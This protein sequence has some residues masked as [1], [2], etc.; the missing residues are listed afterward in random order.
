[1]FKGF[2]HAGAKIIP[3]LLRRLIAN[4]A[5]LMGIKLPRYIQWILLT[6]LCLLTVMSL[7]RLCFHLY[8]GLGP[9]AGGGKLADAFL[10]GLRYDL[11]IVAIASLVLF[12]FGLIKPLHP[13]NTKRG[14]RVSFFL[15]G[16][17]CF[18]FCLLYIADFAH[19]AYLRQRLNASVL[20]YLEDAAISIKMAWQSYP[21]IWIIVALAGGS[22]LLAW[23]VKRCYNY[24]LGKQAVLTGRSR[25]VWGIVFFLLLALAIFGRVG[26]YPL[27][28]SDAYGLGNDYAANLSLNPFQSFFSS[29][30][31][32]HSGYDAKALKN[33]YPWMAN[34]LEVTA[35]HTDSLNFLRQVSAFDSAFQQP[36]VILVLCES[37]SSFKSSSFNNP[38]NSTPYFD[39][40]AKQGI[41]FTNCYTPC[42]GTARGVWATI[43]GV[44]DVEQS[45]TAS[46]NPAM[47]DQHTII[48]SFEGYEK[49]Y[50][51]GG[52]SSW[53]N[54]RGLLTNN[55]KGLK[56]FEEEHFKAPKVDV[57]GISDKNLFLEAHAELEKTDKPFFAII[58]T[59]GNHR[60]YTIPEEDL[61]EFNKLDVPVDSLNNYGF[62]NVE[63]Y[64][65]FRYM[66]YS[67][68]KFMQAASTAAYFRNTV[69]VFIGDHGI[70]GDVGKILPKKAYTE[71]GLTAMHVPLLFY[72]PGMQPQKINSIASQVDVLPTLAGL[73][74]ISYQNKGLGRD[75]LKPHT[76]SGTAFYFDVEGRRYGIIRDSLFYSRSL[77]SPAQ[78]QLWSL[79]HD[80]PVPGAEKRKEYENISRAFYE[81][82]RYM[83]LN[84]KKNP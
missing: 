58:Q 22:V 67:I 52:S 55:I 79:Y 33:A 32:R 16:L 74:N 4:F 25:I 45:K 40:L 51:L 63:E 71:Q 65:A 5:R 20:N 6:G 72:K 38:L 70:R 68:R 76:V 54:I 13:V 2:Q 28:W 82:A 56:L 81:T 60:P 59:A 37:F 69:F 30:K 84:N 42:Y 75:L 73:A 57:W 27:R 48:N 77:Q 21:V 1:M 80:D 46:R 47:V 12:I 8:F 9:D 62:G 14:L 18:F 44:P 53:A 19:Y 83:L 66:D 41:F 7:L 3:I 23:L 36:N 24:V 26:Q 10:L 35:P 61:G 78:E 15:I 11:R 17:F 49:Y 39:S 31:F 50:F 34:Y 43:T 64:N 29:L